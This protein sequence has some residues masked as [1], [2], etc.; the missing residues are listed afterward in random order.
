MNLYDRA[1]APHHDQVGME[2][3]ADSSRQWIGHS[4]HA[5]QGIHVFPEKLYVVTVL[6]NPLRWRSRYVNYFDFQKHVKDA[7][8]ELVTVELALGGRHF[9]VTEPDNPWHVQ[10]RTADEMFHKENL[11][12]LGAWRL[13]LG[14]KYLAF[15][16][17]DMIFTRPDWVQET[18][19]QLQHYDVVQMFTSYSDQ[20][21]DHTLSPLMYSFMW[22]YYHWQDGRVNGGAHSGYQGRGKF[23]GA[24]GGAWAYRVDA[25]KA[26]G[27]LMDRCIVGAADWHMAIGLVGTDGHSQLH[28]E[29]VHCGNPYKRYIQLWQRNSSRL[30]GNVGYVNAHMIHKYHGQRQR[31]AYNQRW[32][33]L[34]QHQYDPYAD[35]MPDHQ[36]V[37]ELSG[38][39]PGMRDDIRRY[40]RERKEDDC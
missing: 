34:H 26:L 30:K 36:G 35:I 12:N 28:L 40:L 23:S 4:S 39:K 8:A 21:P 19:H 37:Y 14:V 5:R 38:E 1:H 6:E 13:P 32:K 27:S 9:E 18:L 29:T 15:I 16:D 24:P 7:G 3:F 33:I 10:L 17:A 11:C 20:Y 25:F 2:H 22:N 31:R